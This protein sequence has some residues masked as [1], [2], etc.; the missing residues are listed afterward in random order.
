MIEMDYIAIPGGHKT[1]VRFPEGADWVKI[2]DAAAR[3]I[4]P[5]YDPNAPDPAWDAMM[6]KR[7]NLERVVSRAKAAGANETPD[8]AKPRVAG[9]RD[10]SQMALEDLTESGERL[11]RKAQVLAWAK[12]QPIDED[13]T[14]QEIASAMGWG[15]NRITGRVVDLIEDGELYESRRRECRI[16]GEYVWALKRGAA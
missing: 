7:K 1:T 5:N 15:I 8:P 13:Y 3:R 11:T 16:T 12:A 4:F 10:T 9:V 14:R 2:A 6:A